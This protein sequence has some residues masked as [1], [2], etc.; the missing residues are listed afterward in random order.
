MGN[1]C[2]SICDDKKAAPTRFSVNEE[3]SNQKL[4][5]SLTTETEIIKLVQDGDGP[6]NQI[7]KQHTTKDI[8]GS[9]S[10]VEKKIS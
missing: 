7:L 2:G 8:A 10:H 6:V 5:R 3:A 4:V 1:V 9:M